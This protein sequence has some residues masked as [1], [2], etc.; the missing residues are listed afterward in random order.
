MPA[1]LKVEAVDGWWL[2]TLQDHASG[3][4]CSCHAET[5]GSIPATLEA[6]LGSGEDVWRPYKSMKVRNP[7]KRQKPLGP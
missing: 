4:Q 5:L 3:Q 2:V 1:T 6:L 7:W